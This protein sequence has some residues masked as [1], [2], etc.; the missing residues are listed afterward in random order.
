MTEAEFQKL[1]ALNIKQIEDYDSATPQSAF[2]PVDEYDLLLE[3]YM[4]EP[5]ATG[6]SGD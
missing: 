2:L 4:S 1:V 6:Y 5:D 3:K